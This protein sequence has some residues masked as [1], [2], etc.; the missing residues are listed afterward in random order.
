MLL[1]FD[2]MLVERLTREAQ[3]L[4]AATCLCSRFPAVLAAYAAAVI[5][6]VAPVVLVVFDE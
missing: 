2:A 5:P 3:G 6:H 1:G 4:A